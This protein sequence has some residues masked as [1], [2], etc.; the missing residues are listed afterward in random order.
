MTISECIC[1][2]IH[3]DINY[4]VTNDTEARENICKINNFHQS[5]VG[6]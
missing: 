6:T 5:F 4:L 2:A 1:V 3:G